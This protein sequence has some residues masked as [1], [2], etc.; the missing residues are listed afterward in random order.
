M[1]LRMLATDAW[2]YQTASPARL[3]F[4]KK[5]VIYAWQRW[6]LDNSPKGGY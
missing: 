1:R 6:I 3:W 5:H 2:I 4:S